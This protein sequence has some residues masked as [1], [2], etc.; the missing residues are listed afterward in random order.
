MTAPSSVPISNAGTARTFRA[1]K[2]MM[3]TGER[4]RPTWMLKASNTATPNSS[5]KAVD[6]PSA[7][8][9]PPNPAIKKTVSAIKRLGTVVRV[10][11]RMWLN[12]SEP[13]TTAAM[14]VVS[15]NGDILSPKY[16]PEMMA[17]A[18]HPSLSP[19]AVPMPTRATP[20]VPTVPHELPV[21][22]ESKPQITHAA[23]KNIPGSRIWSP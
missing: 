22:S 6:T 17:P 7:A 14:F 16:A 11:Y 5:A 23:N 12:R 20:T 2:K 9:A 4:N 21:A 10:M 1:I 18:I 15:L 3:T 8:A 19:E 13:P